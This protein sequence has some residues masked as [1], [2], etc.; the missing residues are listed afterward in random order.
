[1]KK[2]FLKNLRYFFKITPCTLSFRTY[3]WQEGERVHHL[4]KQIA[5]TQSKVTRSQV[6]S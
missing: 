5:A 6:P 1:M 4:N 3:T 2:I